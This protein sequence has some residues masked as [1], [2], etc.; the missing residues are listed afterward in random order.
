MSR[1]FQGQN[2]RGGEKHLFAPVC[3]FPNSP[4]DQYFFAHL[5]VL[6]KLELWFRRK[7][8]ADAS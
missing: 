4:T 3:T 5:V 7:T 2:V 1:F 6:H 8:D